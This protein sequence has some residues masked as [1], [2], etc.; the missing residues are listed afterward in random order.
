MRRVT[1]FGIKINN[2]FDKNFCRGG[3]STRDLRATPLGN[4]NRMS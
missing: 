2:S 3:H 4:P 1:T